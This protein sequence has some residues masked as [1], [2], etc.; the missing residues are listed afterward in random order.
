MILPYSFLT[1][2]IH[3]SDHQSLY[4]HSFTC[5]LTSS[6]ITELVDREC[7]YA[8]SPIERGLVVAR[9]IVNAYIVATKLTMMVVKD[10]AN[11]SSSPAIHEDTSVS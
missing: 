5:V 1:R 3:L 6:G 2:A 9:K 4:A 10:L 8:P 11:S 7:K